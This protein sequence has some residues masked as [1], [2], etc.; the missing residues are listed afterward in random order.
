FYEGAFLEPL[1]LR[2]GWSANRRRRA[3][4]A[5]TVCAA[6][7]DAAWPGDREHPVVP[8]FSCPFRAAAGSGG[9][10]AC[11]VSALGIPPGF[12]RFDPG[13]RVRTGTRGLSAGEPA[14]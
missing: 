13:T 9:Q 6:G 7:L 1:L 14:L 4:S 12:R 2:R 5:W 3:V 8:H 11:A 10:R